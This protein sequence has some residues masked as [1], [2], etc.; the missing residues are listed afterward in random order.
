MQTGGLH[1]GKHCP[2]IPDPQA[3]ADVMSLVLV[4]SPTL[5]TQ[6]PY[7]DTCKPLVYS[8][9][10]VYTCNRILTSII[11]FY[12]AGILVIVVALSSGT[13]LSWSCDW[14]SQIL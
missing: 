5:S 8:K 7:T 10:P 14:D 1:T 2:Y 6:D 9:P 12:N 4:L 3:E 11:G 13:G